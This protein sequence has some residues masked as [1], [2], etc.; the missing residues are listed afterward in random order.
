MSVEF[1]AVRCPECGKVILEVA[2][3]LVRG[4]CRGCGRRV[5][6]AARGG[7]VHIEMLDVPRS[8]L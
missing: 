7:E 4:K 6:A 5:W 8:K 2:F 3:G 1:Q